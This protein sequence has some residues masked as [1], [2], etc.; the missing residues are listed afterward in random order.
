MATPTSPVGEAPLTM[1]V[2]VRMPCSPWPGAVLAPAAP[3]AN[4]GGLS[5]LLAE[6]CLG[7]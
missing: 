6:A 3:E 5:A 1:C 2:R 7:A 4:A